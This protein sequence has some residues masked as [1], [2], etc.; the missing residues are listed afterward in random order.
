MRPSRILKNIYTDVEHWASFSSPR[1]LYKAAKSKLPNLKY[2]DVVNYL[3]S[4]DVYTL[5]R[6]VRRKFPHRKMI[7]RGIHHQYQTDLIDVSKYKSRNNNITFLLGVIDCFSRRLEIE[8]LR[9]KSAKV[10]KNGLKKILKRFVFSPK[11]LQSDQGL[12]Y[13]NKTVQ[14]YLASKKI[15]HIVPSSDS[16]SAIIERVNRTIMT[17]LSRYFTHKKTTHYLNVLQ[18]IVKAYN[19]RPHRSLPKGIS[20]N[21]VTRKNEKKIWKFQ[22]EDYLKSRPKRFK[23]SLGCSVRISK[24]A[25]VF[26]KGYLTTFSTEIFTIADRIASK[27]QTYKLID[28]EGNIL[29]GIFY[30]NELQRV[31][32]E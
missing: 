6:S 5:H 11:I 18:K 27:P 9:N 8:P 14:T 28:K 20:P 3:E 29:K 30:H 31:R 21:M 25:R 23:F 17:R 12:E 10:V 32:N 2:K 22:Y 13:L 16:K 1:T 24:L 4:E 26:R 19:N 7:V 15:K